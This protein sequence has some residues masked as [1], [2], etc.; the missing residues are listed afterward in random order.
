MAGGVPTLLIAV[1]LAVEPTAAWLAAS[2]RHRRLRSA[3]SNGGR[4][5]AG[6]LGA[7]SDDGAA[8]EPLTW[9][10]GLEKA[11][12]PRTTAAQRQASRSSARPTG[13]SQPISK[14]S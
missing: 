5:P 14:G 10:E 1:L 7:S 4:P 6:P 9:Q 11:L 2:T 3:S 13:A 12:S 8:M